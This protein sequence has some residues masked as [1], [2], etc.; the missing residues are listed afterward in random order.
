MGVHF[1]TIF[2][3]QRLVLRLTKDINSNQPDKRRYDS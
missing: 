1:E 2:G 3:R